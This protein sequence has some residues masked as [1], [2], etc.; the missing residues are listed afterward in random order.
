MV[1]I[2]YVMLSPYLVKHEKLRMGR[3]EMQISLI[4]MLLIN[5]LFV[6]GVCLNSTKAT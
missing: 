5:Y 3:N 4:A 2:E 6:S 1:A